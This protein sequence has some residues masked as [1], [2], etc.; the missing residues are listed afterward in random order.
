[1]ENDQE[2]NVVDPRKF[3]QKLQE[4]MAGLYELF[5]LTREHELSPVIDGVRVY[6]E[7]SGKTGF[8]VSGQ[9]ERPGEFF[10][11]LL[12][13]IHV[14]F[15]P[16]VLGTLLFNSNI[17]FLHEEIPN[18]DFQLGYI[19]IVSDSNQAFAGFWENKVR[20]HLQKC[21]YNLREATAIF[22]I[23]TTG[24]DRYNLEFASEI[25]HTLDS[26]FSVED[27]ICLIRSEINTDDIKPRKKIYSG[28][29]LDPVLGNRIR[30]SLW[31]FILR[32]HNRIH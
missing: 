27:V 19:S 15:E 5:E 31:F 22:A 29:C 18:E 13:V 4:V 3:D 30:L 14:N 26:G 25:M 20:Q 6:Y 28:F 16:D 8:Q 10:Q 21:G 1:M 32:I 12:D 7:E 17:C 11:T 24:E 2:M 23:A 9:F